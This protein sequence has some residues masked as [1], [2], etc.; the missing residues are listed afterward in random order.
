MLWRV[1]LTTAALTCTLS[2]THAHGPRDRIKDLMCV[3]LLSGIQKEE[4]DVSVLNKLRRYN[5]NIHDTNNGQLLQEC[6][7]LR[8]ITD[9]ET[10]SSTLTY[11]TTA[12]VTE[13]LH[14]KNSSSANVRKNQIESNNSVSL[15]TYDANIKTNNDA[16]QYYDGKPKLDSVLK[17]W[18]DMKFEHKITTETVR[19]K[20]DPEISYVP[21]TK[22]KRDVDVEPDEEDDIK[23]LLDNYFKNKKIKSGKHDTEATTQ[24]GFIDDYRG[25][26][27][28]RLSNKRADEF[29][30]DHNLPYL[31]PFG[32]QKHSR[33]PLRIISDKD[34]SGS[35][36]D[37]EDNSKYTDDNRKIYQNPYSR[38]L[39]DKERFVVTTERQREKNFSKDMIKE[40]ADSVKELVLRDLK[41]KLQETTA[42]TTTQT[43]RVTSK[44]FDII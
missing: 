28:S 11:N 44:Y 13:N 1:I 9:D 22:N 19:E 7:T 16:I 43:T 40:I 38:R 2:R 27:K 12:G 29:G 18:N 3:L 8:N 20:Y 33:S 24:R 32:G 35:H 37:Y 15:A 6:M 23:K 39:K 36:R 25:Y 34:E 21:E 17:F 5:V 31:L 4:L 14:V 41:L 26:A 10:I 30:P 42:R